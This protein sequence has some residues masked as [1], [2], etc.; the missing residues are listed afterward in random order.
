MSKKLMVNYLKISHL[1]LSITA[2]VCYKKLIKQKRSLLLQNRNNTPHHLEMI[3]KPY[4]K[5][6]NQYKALTLIHLMLNMNQP[7]I[8][9]QA[10]WDLIIPIVISNRKRNQQSLKHKPISNLKN[11]DNRANRKRVNLEAIPLSEEKIQNLLWFIHQII[12]LT[13]TLFQ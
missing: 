9:K 10:F 11:L 4:K 2:N 13:L 7:K 5:L 8:K 3:E 1:L 6:N 12:H